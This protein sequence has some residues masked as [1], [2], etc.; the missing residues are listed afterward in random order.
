VKRKSHYTVS[1]VARL[2]N[3]SVRALH[4]YDEIGLLKPS[5]RSE[6]SYRLYSSADLQRLQQVMSFKV[7]GF[8]LAQI[9]LLLA[10]P[11]FDAKQ[12]L[13]L[14]RRLLEEKAGEVKSL[15]AAVD[16]ALASL[17]KG[18]NTMDSKQMFGAFENFDPAQF[19]EE[20][21]E[22]WG[23]TEAYKESQRRAA[24]YTKAQWSELRNEADQVYRQLADKLGAGAKVSETAVM[25]LAE[26]HRQHLVRWFYPCSP[27]MHRRLGDLYVNDPR[28]TANIDKYGK[29]LAAF[30]REAI[31]AN[32]DRQEAKSSP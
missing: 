18:A 32:A 9:R 22:R 14:Q 2:A 15:I 26:Q 3:L 5:G 6:T 25:D 13:L 10:D 31:A 20:A 4:H 30:M 1:E 8:P 21:R 28:F 24:R 11:E 7:L 27:E 23:K 17:K 16:A 19:E 12:A 29:G